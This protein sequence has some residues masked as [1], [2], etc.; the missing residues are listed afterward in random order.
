NV[1]FQSNPATDALAGDLLAI[2][3]DTFQQAIYWRPDLGVV[4][5]PRQPGQLIPLPER[6]Q[7]LPFVPR[8]LGLWADFTVPGAFGLRTPDLDRLRYRTTIT[9]RLLDGAGAW[10]RVPFKVT[11]VE[12]AS[13]GP[14]SPG[15]SGGGAFVTTGWAYLESDLSILNYQPVSPVRL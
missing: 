10:L 11:E 6:G 2:D 4:Q 5:M 13:T 9:A 8:K 15:V 1:N 7:P 14:Q 3:S 12:Y